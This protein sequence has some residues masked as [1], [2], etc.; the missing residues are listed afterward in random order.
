MQTEVEGSTIVRVLVVLVVT[1]RFLILEAEMILVVE[2]S[3]R[4][5]MGLLS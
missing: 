1:I 5:E 3:G 4:F 2:T